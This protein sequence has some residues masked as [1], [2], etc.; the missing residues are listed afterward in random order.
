MLVLFSLLG[1][2]GG[3]V[4]RA[5]RAVN[6]KPQASDLVF[7]V[8]IWA[9]AIASRINLYLNRWLLIGAWV[10][11]SLVFGYLAIAGRDKASFL[12]S[13]KGEAPKAPLP[14]LKKIWDNWKSFAERM[15]SFQSRVIL[16]FF[17]FLFITPLA[18]A[19]K[20]FSD[21]LGLKKCS[22]T[23]HWLEK[24]KIKTDLAEMRRQF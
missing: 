24:K 7:I 10:V 17:F 16:S 8:I 12:R 1:Y 9:A 5:G 23:T 2:S 4:W 18:L 13:R 19:T 3:A 15:G 21:P 22:T 6:L 20:A 14:I 11:L